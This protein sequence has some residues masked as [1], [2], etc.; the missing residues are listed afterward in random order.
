MTAVYLDPATIVAGLR[1]LLARKFKRSGR[2]A[3]M[4]F[5]MLKAKEPSPGAS[6]ALLSKGPDSVE[7]ELV[8]FFRVADGTTNP[9]VNP[10]GQ[11]D[12]SVE[13]LTPGYER[14]GTYTHLYPG[15]NL[16]SIVNAADN[17]NGFSVSIPSTAASRIATA[18]GE[19]VPLR[20]TAAFLLRSETFPDPATE[21][22][23]TTR[24]RQLF[25]LTQDEVDDLF[26]LDTDFKMNFSSTPFVNALSSLPVDLQPKLSTPSHAMAVI[27]QKDA[28][29]LTANNDAELIFE[30]S[31]RRRLQRAVARTKAVALV[32][33]PGTA[34]SR[35]WQA[36]L[37]DA[38]AT[39]SILGLTSPPTYVC[40][41]AEVDWTA[42][43]L[44]GGHYPQQDGQLIFREGYLLQAI[45]HNQLLWIEEM[46]RADLDRVLGPVLTFLAGQN[47]D[48][49]VTSL[50]GDTSKPMSLGW[51][52]EPESKVIEEKDQR[53]YLAGSDWRMIGTYNNVDR[54]RVFPMGSALLR[55]WAL[56]PI[57][58]ISANDLGSLL[59]K[60][61]ISAPVA[62]AITAAYE[63]HLR[64]L[65]IG[66]APFLDMARYVGDEAPP[67]ITAVLT[68]DE[69]KLLGDAYVI[70]MGQQLSR[71]DPERRDEFL[72]SLGAIFGASVASEAAGF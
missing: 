21:E 8:R 48:L 16:H 29:A 62:Q 50:G 46:N 5:L 32:G 61:A 37:N 64:M 11:S 68:S 3:L 47:V 51:I 6:F 58:P 14:R 9:D 23:V 28:I 39:P 49:G 26:E 44:I 54:G 63:L 27:A 59:G 70:F 60:M 7:P 45:R 10:F 17:G 42:R 4:G 56:V 13:F 38:V 25:H 67:A 20:A 18:L 65:P 2:T 35:L 41:T 36:V 22:V 15:R 34:K 24:F 43:T 19:K 69:Q 53:L 40:Y 52:D 66:A 71:L 57:P 72:I 33:L 31:V 1:E 30:E 12:G 55:R